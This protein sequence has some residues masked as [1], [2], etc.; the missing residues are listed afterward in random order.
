MIDFCK[1]TREYVL[2]REVR[3]RSHKIG[4]HSSKIRT[5]SH[6]FRENLLKK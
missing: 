4:E 1:V 6:K 2:E 3:R 5:Q